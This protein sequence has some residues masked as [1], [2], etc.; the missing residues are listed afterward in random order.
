MVKLWLERDVAFK[1]KK[2]EQ[3]ISQMANNSN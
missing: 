3:T 1:S 2:V